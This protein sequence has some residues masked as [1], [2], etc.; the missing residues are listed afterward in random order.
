MS[1]QCY[2]I[3]GPFIAED[4][5]CPA[6]GID[7]QREREETD[8]LLHAAVAGSVHQFFKELVAEAKGPYEARKVLNPCG[9]PITWFK[10]NLRGKGRVGK[11]DHYT[12]EYI[13][14]LSLEDAKLRLALFVADCFRQR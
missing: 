4:P 7:A 10:Q 6:H 5:T 2:Q 12:D 13:D 11:Y 3:G 9:I 8:T 14:S 1:C